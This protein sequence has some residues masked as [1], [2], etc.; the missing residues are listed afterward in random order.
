MPA[1]PFNHAL[2]RTAASLRSCNRHVSW[3][4]SLSLGRSSGC[5]RLVSMA[6]TGAVTSERGSDFSK[7]NDE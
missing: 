7:E 5:C 4:P 3:P 6:A 1:K 2:Q